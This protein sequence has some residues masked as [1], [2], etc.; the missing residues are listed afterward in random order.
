MS[1]ETPNEPILADDYP[2]YPGYAY[3]VDGKVILSD[4]EGN[5]GR[6]KKV[7]KATEVRRCDLSARDLL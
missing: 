3:V 7:M 2:V 6:L 5:V 1:K 4:I